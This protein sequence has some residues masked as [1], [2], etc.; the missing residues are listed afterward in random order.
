[1]M[2][3]PRVEDGVEAAVTEVTEEAVAEMTEDME[4]VEVVANAVTE[5]AEADVTEVTDAEGADVETVAALVEL[6][7]NVE[8]TVLNKA[9]EIELDAA[10]AEAANTEDA[11]GKASD[12]ELNTVSAVEAVTEE[13]DK[14]VGEERGAPDPLLR[15]GEGAFEVA[16]VGA[17]E[18][19][20][21]EVMDEDRG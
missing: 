15:T 14:V 1:M 21:A 6:D 5:K 16:R 19:E 11:V 8:V 12:E 7:A 9:G 13:L 4:V 17:K 10:S 3:D 2:V 20:V 18:T